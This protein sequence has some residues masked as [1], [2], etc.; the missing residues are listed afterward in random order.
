MNTVASSRTLLT[1][2][3][4]IDGKPNNLKLDKGKKLNFVN[5][6]SI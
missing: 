2:H 6:I 4:Y 5:S 3:V 1:E